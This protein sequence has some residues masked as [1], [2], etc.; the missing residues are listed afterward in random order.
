MAVAESHA[1][2]DASRHVVFTVIRLHDLAQ[3]LDEWRTQVGMVRHTG[4]VAEAHGS[5]VQSLVGV[6]ALHAGSLLHALL[7]V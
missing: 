3:T 7:T 1:Q 5:F 6:V 4:G 2:P